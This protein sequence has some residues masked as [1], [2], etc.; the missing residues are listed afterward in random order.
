MASLFIAPP[1]A[2][3]EID[4][5]QVKIIVLKLLDKAG[6]DPRLTPRILRNKVEDKMNIERGGL[7]VKR[8]YIKTL[9]YKWWKVNH[10]ESTITGAPLSAIKAAATASAVSSS[11]SSSSSANKGDKGKVVSSTSTASATAPPEVT[12]EEKEW[13]ALIRV[14][15]AGD[16]WPL[17]GKG[18]KEVD[19]KEK[20]TELR[21]RYV[22][23]TVLDINHHMY[24]HE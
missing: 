3:A 9:I 14:A 19:I 10:P 16:K 12:E 13:K 17:L 5:A 21:K 1:I 20:I 22:Y 4:Q 6:N 23:Y 7:K 11:G 2:M 15:K 8:D 24:F 18:L